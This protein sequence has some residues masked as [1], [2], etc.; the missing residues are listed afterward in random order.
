M[1]S[2]GDQ[3][4]Y[5]IDWDDGTFKDWFG[6]FESGNEV[7]VSHIWDKVDTYAIKVKAKDAF[8]LESD[9]GYLP[10]EISRYKIMNSPL[11]FKLRERFPDAL[12]FIRKILSLL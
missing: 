7:V 1:D 3:V 12:F 9:W 11:F 2:N 10:I 4:F 6:P 8:G 5:Y